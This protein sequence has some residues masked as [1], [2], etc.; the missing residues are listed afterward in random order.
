MACTDEYPPCHT[1]QQPAS[2]ATGKPWALLDL[3]LGETV[4]GQGSPQTGLPWQALTDCLESGIWPVLLTTPG[5]ATQQADSPASGKPRAVLAPTSW[6]ASARA[7]GA[8]VRASGA[9]VRASRASV[10][11]SGASV[12]QSAGEGG[13]P[14]IPQASRSQRLWHQASVLSAA[15]SPPQLLNHVCTHP[16]C[17]ELVLR[18]IYGGVSG[19]GFLALFSKVFLSAVSETVL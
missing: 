12:S 9:S 13:Y 1:M 17:I 19:I 2:P 10:R 4:G 6:A 3:Q 16:C 11:A 7:R 18:C 14:L 5:S 8:S 15:R